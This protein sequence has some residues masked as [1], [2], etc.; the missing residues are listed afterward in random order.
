MLLFPALSIVV[1]VKVLSSMKMLSAVPF[2]R[3]WG[4]LPWVPT[5]CMRDVLPALVHVL[6]SITP[7]NLIEA[8]DSPKNTTSPPLPPEVKVQVL[9]SIRKFVRSPL[10]PP[11][12]SKFM[13]GPGTPDVKLNPE[14]R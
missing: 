1:T 4:A 12:E 13:I 11:P 7:E 14:M 3:E 8:V 2:D 10:L 9:W 6:W 5:C